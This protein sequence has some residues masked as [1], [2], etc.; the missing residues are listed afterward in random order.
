MLV[1]VSKGG[2]INLQ[3]RAIPQLA[4][5]NAP[6]KFK[7]GET[8][9]IARESMV[10]LEVEAASICG[11]D[12]HILG[13]KHDSTE[14]VV[15]GHEYIGRVIEVGEAVEKVKA[16]DRVAVD[17]NVKCYFRCTPC[18]LGSTNKCEN[19]TTLGIFTDGGFAQFNL[20]PEGAL[21]VLP[22]DLPVERAVLFEPLSTVVH[23][24]KQLGGIHAPERVLIHGAGP[25]GSLFTVLARVNGASEVVVVEPTPFRREHILK[26]GATKVVTPS[27]KLKPA[28]FDVV[29]DASG[30]D[31]VVPLVIQHARPGGRVL[32]FGQQNIDAEATINE[33]VA[34]QNELRQIGSY[35]T[36]YTFEDTIQLLADTR[37]PFERFITHRVS[38]SEIEKAFEHMREGNAVKILISPR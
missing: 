35:A 27:E 8:F 19:M 1:A 30:R 36:S 24:L 6:K 26:V 9:H 13:G 12:L 38:L 33:T 18:N 10:L 22:N 15:L 5:F 11:T 37:I 28:S 20:A 4:D 7:R 32:W 2:K 3:E 16:G 14:G 21:H 23:G 31:E 29:I 17:P 25:I 34:N